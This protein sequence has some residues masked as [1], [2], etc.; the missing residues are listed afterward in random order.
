MWQLFYEASKFGATII[1]IFVGRRII[2]FFFEKFARNQY[3]FFQR[4][5]YKIY[6]EKPY[7]GLTKLFIMLICMLKNISKNLI[8]LSI[9]QNA[10][11]RSL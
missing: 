3:V 8:I 4:N 1:L 6:N 2:S 10:K 11:I 7:S 5:V 9:A